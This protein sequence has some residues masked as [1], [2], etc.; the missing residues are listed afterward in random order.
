MMLSMQASVVSMWNVE[1]MTWRSAW[2]MSM[3]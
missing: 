2:K 1:P 3:R